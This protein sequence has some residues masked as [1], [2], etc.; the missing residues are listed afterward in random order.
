VTD[1]FEHWQLIAGT[2]RLI[3]S[4]KTKPLHFLYYVMCNEY[5]VSVAVTEASAA[6]FRKSP[7]NAKSNEL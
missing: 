5:H 4:V 2:R 3:I 7:M 1:G 6:P